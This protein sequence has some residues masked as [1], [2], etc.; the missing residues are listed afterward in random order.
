MKKMENH[1][2]KM[3]S[4]KKKVYGQWFIYAWLVGENK[5]GK[6]DKG[7]WERG[8]EKIGRKY[9]ERKEMV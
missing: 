8:E 1:T 5:M 7:K 6:K 9:N 3:N 2:S 4:I